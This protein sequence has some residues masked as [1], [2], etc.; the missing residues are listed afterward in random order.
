MDQARIPGKQIAPYAVGTTES[1][2]A[3]I[4]ES[5][6]VRTPFGPAVPEG[7]WTAYFLI[8]PT[9]G[10]YMDPVPA[11]EYIY[12]SVYYHFEVDCS[13]ATVPDEMEAPGLRR[14]W[15]RALPLELVPDAG[16]R[17]DMMR[18][19]GVFFDL[20]PEPLDMD[21]QGAAVLVELGVPPDLPLDKIPGEH[22]V[23][24]G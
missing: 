23:H 5:F 8:L 15:A 24:V 7:R 12:E 9:S 19:V 1:G 14:R 6:K 22:L 21:V 11:E 16:D 20:L 2:S 4:F 18:V 17:Y 10:G 13:S 3:A